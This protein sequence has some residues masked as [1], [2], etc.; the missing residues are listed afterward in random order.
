VER[1]TTLKPREAGRAAL[2]QEEFVA[3]LPDVDRERFERPTAQ[4]RKAAEDRAMRQMGGGEL[5][6]RQPITYDMGPYVVPTGAATA[7][8]REATVREAEAPTPTLAP[9]ISKGEVT[10]RE[11]RKEAQ[12]KMRAFRAA[13]KAARVENGG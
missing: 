4:Q 5:R 10:P 2:R 1:T 3:N 13:Q 8:S 12:Q 11:E 6:E 7:E 9:A